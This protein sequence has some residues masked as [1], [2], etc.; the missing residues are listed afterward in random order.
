MKMCFR[1][2]N[3]VFN[4]RYIEKN[5]IIPLKQNATDIGNIEGNVKECFLCPASSSQPLIDLWVT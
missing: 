3:S 4:N 5:Y 1:K 2:Q